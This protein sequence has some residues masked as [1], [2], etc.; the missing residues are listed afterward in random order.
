MKNLKLH[1]QLSLFWLVLFISA[2]IAFPAVQLQLGEVNAK[3]DGVDLTDL[4]SNNLQFE[5]KFNPSL[6]FYGGSEIVYSIGNNQGIAFADR[7]LDNAAT[8]LEQRL[9]RIGLQNYTVYAR[10]SQSGDQEIVVRL[11]KSETELERVNQLL[12]LSGD[13][14]FIK[15]F[16]PE[17]EEGSKEAPE[18]QTI[19]TNFSKDDITGVSVVY[20]AE[21]SGYG[22]AIDFKQ[23]KLSEL[24]GTALSDVN[25]DSQDQLLVSIGGQILAGQSSVLNSGSRSTRIL[26]ATGLGSDSLAA[27]LMKDMFVNSQDNEQYN[28][29]AIR[30]VRGYYDQLI[31]ALKVAVLAILIAALAFLVR[32]YRARGVVFWLNLVFVVVGSVALFKLN[33]LG[34]SLVSILGVVCALLIWINESKFV[35]TAERSQWTEK[36]QQQRGSFWRIFMLTLGACLV[37]NYTR[38]PQLMDFCGYFSITLLVGLFSYYF[39]LPL[40]FNLLKF[41]KT[42]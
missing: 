29:S 42:K 9:Q 6:D 39:S 22:L 8:S 20:G 41:S 31:P 30:E 3:F 16:Y 25:N 2:A 26:F 11:P 14:Q 13:P 40:T 27:E 34:L 15:Q 1:L 21:T 19:T 4:T 24:L 36:L 12:S 7:R 32:S 37:L 28:V 23:E 35:L 10:T 5:F 33:T 17:A 38:L 18:P